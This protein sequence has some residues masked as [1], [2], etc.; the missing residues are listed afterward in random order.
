MILSACAWC[1][2]ALSKK[3]LVA[4]GLDV[5]WGSVF[6]ALL[7]EVSFPAWARIPSFAVILR[8]LHSLVF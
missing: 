3:D 5:S 2:W 6:R 1:A 4:R 8:H 7:D